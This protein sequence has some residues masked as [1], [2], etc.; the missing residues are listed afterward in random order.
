MTPCVFPAH[1]HS[2]SVSLRV[3]LSLSLPP[4]TL[5]PS[6]SLKPRATRS[7][8]ETRRRRSA[9]GPQAPAS[10]AHGRRGRRALGSG[11]GVCIV[12]GCDLRGDWAGRRKGARFSISG[13]QQRLLRDGRRRPQPLKAGLSPL[14]NW[15]GRVPALPLC[16]PVPG[17]PPLPFIPLASLAPGR[18]GIEVEDQGGESPSPWLSSLPSYHLMSQLVYVVRPAP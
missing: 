11:L 4:D 6:A 17:H 3:S 10:R 14:S 5:A 16:R 12:F 13:E 9:P 7:P 15:L 1:T 8:P 18:E 2:V